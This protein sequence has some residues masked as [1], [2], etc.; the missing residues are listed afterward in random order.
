MVWGGE[1]EDSREGRGWTVV[2]CEGREG[3]LLGEKWKEG[4]LAEE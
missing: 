4:L 1:C 2:N 3:G